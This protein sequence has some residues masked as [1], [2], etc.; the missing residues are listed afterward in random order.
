MNNI[1]EQ[2]THYLPSKA[3]ARVSEYEEMTFDIIDEKT[4]EEIGS[5]SVNE[6]G[7]LVSFSLFE[8]TKQG[9]V[10]RDEIAA[11]ADKFLNTFHP[12]KKEY[13]LSAILDLDNP[14][15]V[16]YEKRDDTYGLFLHSM[17]FVVSVSTAG[18]VTQFHF[19]EEEYE[20]QNDVQVITKE[21]ALEQ[22]IDQL[23]FALVIEHYDHEVYKNGDSKYHLSYSLIEHVTDIP[24]DGSEPFSIREENIG[25]AKIP[26]QE[27]SN[28]S[29]YELVGITP[30]YK[31]LDVLKEEG[32]KTELWTK[33]ESIDSSSFEMDEPDNHV[34]KLIF[35][36][37]TGDLLG[38]ISG[39]ESENDG[40]EI[41]LEDA[42]KK[43][44]DFMFNLFPNTNERFRLEV[45]EE[46]DDE[47]EFEDDEVDE[48]YEGE[49]D[50]EEEFESD[51][52]IEDEDM[53][54]EEYIEY[55]QTYTFYFHLYQ[56]DLRVD[57]H[58]SSLEVGKFTGKITNFD[59]D[60]PAPEQYKH[61]LT[62]PK[63]S[64]NEAKQIYKNQL[65][66]ELVFTREYD[67]NE[68]AIYK[69]SYAPSFPST[70]G[71]VRAIEAMT[72]EAMFVDVGDATFL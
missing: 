33:L 42:K 50:L 40:E 35:D 31:L 36:E 23:D 54:E 47:E 22:Y 41:S 13:E 30:E 53:D 17:G 64:Y 16:V 46:F 6:H 1:I 37:K 11:I 44:I 2:L 70:V 7:E 49:S 12:T 69:L 18:Q 63:I 19:T 52:D 27:P 21:E 66:M 45:L 15:M 32:K 4:D 51:F 14:Y 72:G 58:V 55:E 25:E 20:I 29:V 60:I 56:N 10:K 5:Y 48:E 26:L 24:V 61:I 59:L 67:E 8:D 39:E 3:I 65:E 38:G 71:H 68:K 43:A 28:K 62:V 57:Q 9:D 34:V